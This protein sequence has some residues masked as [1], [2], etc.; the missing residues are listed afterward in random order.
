MVSV[1]AR[2][3]HLLESSFAREGESTRRAIIDE[4]FSEAER[5]PFMKLDFAGPAETFAVQ[6]VDTLLEFGS[7]GHGRHSLSM[8]LEK[9]ATT[10]GWQTDGDPLELQRELDAMVAVP[11][12]EEELSYLEGL[13]AK[14]ESKARLYSPLQGVGARRPKSDNPALL[15]GWD[16]PEIALLKFSP[17][18]QATEKKVE[19]R[20]YEDVLSAFRDQPRVALLGDP[21]SGPRAQAEPPVA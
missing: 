21:G 14:T 10:P 9:L 13:I 4:A 7:A 6:T 2:A 20:E 19:T 8:L 12:R 17:R 11:A 3:V 1:K 18:K 5:N 15:A 16:E